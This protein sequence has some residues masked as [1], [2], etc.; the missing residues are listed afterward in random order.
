MP[1]YLLPITCV[2]GLGFIGVLWWVARPRTYWRAVPADQPKVEDE[3]AARDEAKAAK[4]SSIRKAVTGYIVFAAIVYVIIFAAE[5]YQKVHAALWPTGTPTTKP[6]L[7]PTGTSIYSPTPRPSM[8][9]FVSPYVTQS[10]RDTT[11]AT[12]TP[13]LITPTNKVIYQ[14]VVQTQIIQNNVT[15]YQTVI[16]QQTVIVPVF[17]YSTVI[18][19][20]TPTPIPT[21]ET[22]TPTWTETPTET[23]TKIP[24]DTSL[25]TNE[26]E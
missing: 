11:S 13:I 25:P 3:E 12:R 1:T 4:V 9:G 15:V 14:P 8:T 7:F 6:T 18:V 5:P 2:L 16:V 19:T 10:T 26:G 22:P 24:I 20:E 23:F 21:S 17:I